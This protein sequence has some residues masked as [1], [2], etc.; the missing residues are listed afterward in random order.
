MSLLRGLPN[1]TP[2]GA[3]M[4][5]RQMKEGTYRAVGTIFNTFE[6][7]KPDYMK[8]YAKEVV[9]NRLWCIGPVSLCNEN[10]LDKFERGHSVSFDKNQCLK[11]L[12]CHNPGSVLYACRLSVLQLIELGAALAALN[13]SFIWVIREGNNELKTWLDNEKCE[14]KV[15]G[16]G[17]IIHGWGPQVL[18]LSHASVGAFLTYCGW[19]S[20]LEFIT[21]G[22][23]MMTWPVYVEQFSNEK[24][25]VNVIKIGV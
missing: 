10:E 15:C 9:D 5:H 18:I 14:Y 20:T 8:E 13:R 2:P 7:I 11:W 12:D 22:L 16:R 25:V 17:L 6:E 24:F 1:S 23:P 21:A 19:N 3:D 4:I